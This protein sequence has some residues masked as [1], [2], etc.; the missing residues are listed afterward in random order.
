MLKFKKFKLGQA[1]KNPLML[2]FSR[3][4]RAQEEMVGFALIIIIVAIILLVFLSISLRNNDRESVESFEIDSFIQAFL[5]QTS[6]CRRTDNLEF[7]SVQRLIFSC[8]Q[9][10]SCLEGANSCEILNETLT[11]ILDESWMVGEDRPI[12]GRTLEITSDGELL[13]FLKEGVIA[14]NSKGGSQEFF[15]SGSEIQI[16]FQVYY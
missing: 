13:L 11:K 12:K 10:D 6:E 14:G 2:T 4:K 9:Q 16:N 8:N 7:L 1:R 3:T 5:Q 15:R